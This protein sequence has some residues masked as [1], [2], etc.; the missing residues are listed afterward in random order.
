L[1]NWRTTTGQDTH[2]F[3]STSA[4]SPPGFV[5]G[6][7]NLNQPTDFALKSGSP[8]INAGVNVGLTENTPDI[9]AIPYAGR[10]FVGF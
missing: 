3:Q 8:C 1:A 9:G 7:G 6:S 5:N 2:S 4:T 10:G